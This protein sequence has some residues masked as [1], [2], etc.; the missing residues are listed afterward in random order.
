[1]A[2]AVSPA[3]MRL[4]AIQTGLRWVA[5]Q[6]AVELVDVFAFFCSAF[7][8]CIICQGKAC[9]VV[10]TVACYDFAQVV[11]SLLLVAQLVVSYGMICLADRVLSFLA[12][13]RIGVLLHLAPFLASSVDGSNERHGW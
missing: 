8:F 9:Q 13:G 6:H 11:Y 3:S 10:Q 5:V 1:M 4:K 7:S 2:S 12:D